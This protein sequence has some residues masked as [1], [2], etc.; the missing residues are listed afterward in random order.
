MY[1]YPGKL[2]L[3]IFSM[4]LCHC[5]YVSGASGTDKVKKSLRQVKDGNLADAF[6]TLKTARL[7]KQDDFGIDYVYSLYFLSPYQKTLKL[8]S[9][10]AFC[11][12]AID[13]FTKED[14][15]GKRKY[16]KL[17]IDSLELYSRK[18]YL[19]SL[20]FSQAQRLESEAAYQYFLERFPQSRLA[21]TAKKNRA[22]LAFQRAKSA[23]SYDA[24]MAFLDKYPD[25]EQA[26]SAQ[27]IS[28]LLVFENTARKGKLSD[29]ETFIEKNPNNP[30]ILKAQNRIYE[31]STTEH[32]AES[33][34]DF[35]QQYPNNPN[36]TQAW[37]WIF[38]L[39]KTGRSLYHYMHR[40][41]GFP[42]VTF[43]NKFENRNSWLIS[44]LERGKFGMLQRRGQAYIKPTYDSIPEEYKCESVWG[45]FIKLFKN[46]KVTIFSLDSVPI[47]DG[48]FDNAEFFAD[49]ILKT[50]KG[51]RQ[52]LIS[53]AGYQILGPRYESIVRL[54]QNLLSIQ[55]GSK[56]YLFTSK[57]QKIDI[58]PLDEVIKAGQYLAVRI[59]DKFAM[60]K[61]TE[62]LKNLQNQPIDLQF[63][64]NK[65]QKV[66]E[67]ELVL[68]QNQ[69]VF[70]F[71]KN[72]ILLLTAKPE[73]T[74]SESAW[75]LMVQ[76]P[77][78]TNIIDSNGI[79]LPKEYQS[80]RIAGQLAIARSGNKFGILAR[81]GNPFL[82]FGYDSISLL[83]RKSYLARKGNKKFLIFENGR[84][85][86]FSGQKNPEVLRHTSPKG[87]FSSYFIMLSDSLDRKAIFNK[88]GRQ[89]VPYQYDQLGLLDQHLF[90][91]VNDKKVGI[92][93]TNGKI[94]VKPSLSGAS[95][96]NKDY[97][98]IAKG[99]N[100]SVVNPFTKKTIPAQLTSIAKPYGP[101]KWFFIVRIKDKAG[102][103]DG[104][105]K[106]V[107]PC[108]YEEVMYWNPTRCLVK[109]GGFWYFYMIES[110]KELVKAMKSVRVLMERENETIY[111]V[112]S[113]KKVGIEST[114]RGEIA[115]TD[116]DDIVPFEAGN[117]IFFFAGRRVQS[118]SVYNLSY[119]DQ[120]GE[121]IKTQLLT[122]D[123]Y[124]KIVCE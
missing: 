86:Y 73:H 19:D 21:E 52:G 5:G 7:K 94:L 44:F 112:E 12:S 66:G 106:L 27:E 58:Q 75:G 16:E 118:S 111:E 23:N 88:Q 28:D 26:R 64:Y 41:P 50:F 38:Y 89:L 62:I 100:F 39:D 48:E 11:L 25:A 67:N 92:A 51:G 46:N 6:I 34:F 99:K 114:L 59:G 65:V 13:K 40:Y 33:Y 122:E 120:N 91:L 29:W 98:C 35:I 72:K 3:L 109:K 54:N 37:E 84:K 105:G 79:G 24:F 22:S 61:E 97:I 8:D 76:K 107:I 4:W 2:C 31:L 56:F 110:G 104:G 18:D 69:E 90:Y 47:S 70:F 82:E 85:V 116:N 17:E 20:G 63:K 1:R 10:Y 103:M 102:L 121:L 123:E 78:E 113:D 87:I 96:I 124:D 77:G 36:T 45:G 32:T 49:G 119:I 57:G 93:D 68:F 83:L 117:Q 74:F 43:E 81:N 53:M 9:S 42:L 115:P 15:A 101:S 30:Y 60:I 55:Q 95:P 80:L 108:I 14:K 71:V